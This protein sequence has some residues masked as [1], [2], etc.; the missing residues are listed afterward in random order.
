MLKH[1][2]LGL[3]AEE[4][5]HGYEIKTE[6]EKML[7]NTWQLNIGQ[8][9]ST[10]ARLERDGL[11]E[12]EEISQER[13][14]NRKVYSLTAAGR[15]KLREWLDEPTLLPVRLKVEFFLKLLIARRAST[16]D[17]MP[18]LWRQRHAYM[19]AMADL[20][21]LFSGAT[22]SKLRLL[23]EGLLLHLDADLKWLDL[24]ERTFDS[25]KTTR[26]EK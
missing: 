24:C 7:G 26:K 22:E 21:E 11:V 16:E 8:V 20:N 4:P 3:L 12:S 14:P 18:I 13:L 1:A 17:I 15:A 19:Q 6:F 9:Y 10:L 5:R 25:T 2:I 23:A